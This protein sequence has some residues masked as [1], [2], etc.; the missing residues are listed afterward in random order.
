M[1]IMT[2][3]SASVGAVM[4]PAGFDNSQGVLSAAYAKDAADAQWKTDAGM[5]KWSEFIDKYMPGAD[6]TDSALVYGYGAAQTLA[7]VL[8]MCGDDLSRANVMKQAASLKDFVPDTLLP[9]VKINTSATDF[10]PISQLQMQRF[11]GEKWEL[12]GD[13]ISGDVST[14]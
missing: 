7:K 10:A 1:Q 6:R 8:E 12:F 9:G 13:I 2:N 11:K 4:Q 3:V 14:Q 5:V